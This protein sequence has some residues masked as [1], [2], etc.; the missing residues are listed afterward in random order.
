VGVLGRWLREWWDNPLLRQT[1]PERVVPAARVPLWSW[2]MIRERLADAGIHVEGA[3]E[4]RY[5][6]YGGSPVPMTSVICRA[7]DR[8]AVVRIVDEILDTADEPPDE[9]PGATPDGSA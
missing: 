3:E 2:P 1:D 6:G 5:P 9:P 4:S 8:D 7:R